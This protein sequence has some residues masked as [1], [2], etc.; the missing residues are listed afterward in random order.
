[1]SSM[2][3]LPS[4]PEHETVAHL[5]DQDRIDAAFEELE[6][7]GYTTLQETCCSGCGWGAVE[8]SGGDPDRAVHYN[9]QNMDDAFGEEYLPPEWQAR[10]DA[11]EA[12][13]DS[14]AVDDIM[15]QTVD[16]SAWLR[17]TTLIETLY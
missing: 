6:Q 4:T 5:T 8:R 10:L 17:P 14:K 9:A 16:E 7:R 12:A 2:G 15:D 1:M 11:A 3:E 13:G